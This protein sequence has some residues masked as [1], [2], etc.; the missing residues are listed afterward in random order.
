[1]ILLTVVAS[2]ATTF[3]RSAGMKRGMTRRWANNPMASSQK[4]MQYIVPVFALSRLYWQHGR[5]CLGHH[6]PVDAQQYVL[7][8]RFP[9][10]VLA[11]RAARRD[12]DTTGG[13]SGTRPAGR[14]RAGSRERDRRGPAAVRSSRG[15][16]AAAQSGRPTGP[17]P[18]RQ[19][20]ASPAAQLGRPLT[21]CAS[22][23]ARRRRRF[24][25]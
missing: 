12:A 3:T 19:R 5:S 14:S 10:P 11:T 6:Q 18:P 9:P 13:K 25:G 2:A 24:P 1:M 4:M 16:A 8:R 21:S 15:W 17:S 20:V 7:F 23:P 22:H